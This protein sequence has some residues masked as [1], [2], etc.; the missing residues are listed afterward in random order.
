MA[1]FEAAT[2]VSRSTANIN[3][4]SSIT[5]NR[6]GK[7]I[8]GDN[9][10]C[11]LQKDFS[12][13]QAPY[14]AVRWSKNKVCIDSVAS[15]EQALS[16]RR[17]TSVEAQTRPHSFTACPG[18]AA[19]PC[20]RNTTTEAIPTAVSAVVVFGVVVTAGIV[21]SNLPKEKVAETLGADKPRCDACGGS[22]ICP[23]CQGEGFVNKELSPQERE[24]ARARSTMAATRYTAGLARKWRYCVACNGSRGC[25]TC[26]GKGYLD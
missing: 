2:Q 13:F 7:C 5:A 20:E 26:E 8:A 14:N 23:V 15:E 9:R 11:T 22:G 12:P 19:R 1:P 24:K 25:T 17:R 6:L 16:R 3:G 10:L 21:L 4:L 18:Q